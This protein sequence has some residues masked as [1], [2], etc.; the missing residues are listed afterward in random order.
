MSTSENIRPFNDSI[1]SALLQ[2]YDDERFTEINEKN[3][4]GSYLRLNKTYSLTIE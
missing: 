4:F 1:M 3:A 2:F